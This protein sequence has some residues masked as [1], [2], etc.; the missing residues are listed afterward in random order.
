MFHRYQYENEY[1]ATLNRVPL[2]VRM[3]LD[4]TGTKISLKDWLAFAITERKVLCHLPVASE[5]E[6]EVFVDYLDFLSRRYRDKPVET[7]MTMSSALWSPSSVP[8]PVMEQSA[9]HAHAMTLEEW[10]RWQP[11]ERY[12]LY[13]TATSTRQPEAFVQVLAQLRSSNDS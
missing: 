7:T 8:E 6:R 13:K 11:H 12:A 3:K 10:A 5:D 1:Y 9:L 4:V 2:D